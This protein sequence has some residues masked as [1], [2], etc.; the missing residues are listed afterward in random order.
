MIFVKN[1]FLKFFSFFNDFI[2]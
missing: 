1:A 2:Y